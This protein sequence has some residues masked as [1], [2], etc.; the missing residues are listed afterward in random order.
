M[1]PAFSV[2][3]TL[4]LVVLAGMIGA[5]A[6]HIQGCTVLGFTA[7]ALVDNL[8]GKGTADRLITVKRG[9]SIT[10]WTKEPRKFTG[11]FLGIS[12]AKDSLQGQPPW[13]I[14]PD[15]HIQLQTADETLVLLADSVVRVSV[16]V[17]SGK[18][19]GT[20]AGIAVDG[21]LI[22]AASYLAYTTAY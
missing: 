9:T 19:V 20:L 14:T 7:G 15:S 4:C 11:R 1:H 13:R 16:P 3:R 18:V 22:V 8:S 5:L 17:S 21:I 12:A 2:R 6:I 10:V